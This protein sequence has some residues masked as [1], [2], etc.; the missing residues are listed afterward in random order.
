MVVCMLEDD[1]DVGT[2]AQTIFDSLAL[3]SDIPEFQALPLDE[4]RLIILDLELPSG[5]GLNVL[6][7]IRAAPATAKTP[8]IIFTNMDTDSDAGLAAGAN[9]WVRKPRD[10]DA[11]EAAL[12]SIRAFWVD[13]NQ[14][15]TQP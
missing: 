12:R 2:L 9:A 8:V 13:L 10:A 15:V 6:R 3:A 5:S 14:V 7:Q 1:P 4:A 11:M